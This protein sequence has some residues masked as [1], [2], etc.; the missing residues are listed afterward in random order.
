MGFQFRSYSFPP[1]SFDRPEKPRL[2][3]VTEIRGPYFTV[4]GPRYLEDILETKGHFVD[5]LKFS[6]GSFSLMPKERVKRITAL[7]HKHGIYVNTGGWAENMLKKGLPFFN[8][9]VQECKDLGF[10]IVELGTDFLDLQEADLLRL[11]RLVKNAGLRAKPELV[12]EAGR[13]SCGQP[14]QGKTAKVQEESQE[15]D[16]LIKRA[17]RCLEAGADMIMVEAQGLTENVPSW[18]TDVLAEII[19]RLGLERT[20]FEAHEPKVF[21]WF[22]NN[23]GPRVNLFVNHCDV[24]ELENLRSGTGGHSRWISL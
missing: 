4:M 15:F 17:E 2:H 20:M 24:V 9:Y 13:I 5:G 3:G 10:D 7:A 23:Y 19:G 6:G 14:G 18:R 21:E 12:F 22:L 11:I 1:A 16:V 8:E